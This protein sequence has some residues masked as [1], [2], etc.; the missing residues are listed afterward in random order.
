MN[1][2]FEHNLAWL[3]L[4]IPITAALVFWLYFYRSREE[5][6]TQR[7]KVILSTVR[8]TV[9]FVL[10][11]LLL[12]PNLIRLIEEVE[13]P[14]LVVYTDESVSVPKEERE[15]VHAWLDRVEE[16]LSERYEVRHMPFGA[17]AVHEGSASSVDTLYTD[18]GAVM[19]SVNEDFYGENIGAVVVASDGIQNKGLDPR[20]VPLNS[21]ARV[22]TLSLGDTSI[23][24]DIELSQL[25]NNRLA[26]LDNQFEIKARIS[27]DKMAGQVSRVRLLHDGEELAQ[28]TLNIDD[29]SFS[30]EISF[31]TTADKVGL[32]KYIVAI[33]IL[34][35]EKNRLNN[36]ADAYIE[37]LD[38]RTTVQII[39]KAPHPDVALI[40]RSIEKNDQYEV[41]VTLLKDWDGRTATADLFI[42][43]GLPTDANDLNHVHRIRTDAKPVFCIVTPT[44]SFRH[45]NAMDLGLTVEARQFQSDAVSGAVNKDFNLF[46]VDGEVRLNRYPPMQAP[47]GNFLLN[48]EHQVL[49][50][51]QVGNIATDKP[52][53]CYTMKD[54]IKAGFVLGE[55]LW[56]W[57]LFEASIDETH[58]TEQWI[59]KSVQYLAIRQKR[60]RLN[61]TAP[62]QVE[63][64]EEVVV[65]AEYYN[66]SY[67]LN[68][69]PE[70]F[71][72]VL[73]SA[74]NVID[75]QFRQTSNAYRL[76]LGALPPGEYA[77]TS[78]VTVENETFEESGTFTVIENR[79]EYVNYVANHALLR[80]LS[81]KK[82]GKMF[83]LADADALTA[84]L[85][86]LE[87]AKPLIHTFKEWSSLIEWEWLMILLVLI[88]SAE[89]FV[90]KYTGYV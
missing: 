27:A 31:I 71:L 44:V 89:W 87:S 76:S 45:F 33:D 7:L 51:Q 29:P 8:W 62:Q 9:I 54:G 79:S 12:I 81:D 68:N 83:Q 61:V 50:R 1:I 46:N 59:Q 22:F 23:L 49:L 85:S 60:T 72:S 6:W 75:Y 70:V 17:Q 88:I 42:L 53:A 19:S 52:L 15:Q 86:Q 66:Q 73:D 90:R 34:D 58:W 30:K 37:V 48:S 18:L 21:G 4:I 28:Q 2:T 36:S 69:E 55:G 5:E 40:K 47:F 63:E 35:L 57:N 25:L 39:A 80:D 43:H 77:W 64:R 24:A 10:C 82:G 16:S 14:R 20:Y 13:R 67:E 84:D 56:K 78:E 26:F 74:G 65:L 41:D 11:L 3:W 32:N 38:N